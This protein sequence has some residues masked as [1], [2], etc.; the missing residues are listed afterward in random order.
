MK[1]WHLFLIEMCV[2][3]GIILIT[4]PFKWDFWR[5]FV[6]LGL[7]FLFGILHYEEGKIVS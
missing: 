4:D 3:L 2:L 6:W 5:I 1:W 7:I